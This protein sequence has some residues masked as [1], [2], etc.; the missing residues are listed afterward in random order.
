MSSGSSSSGVQKYE[1]S[2]DMKDR[3]N[4]ALNRGERLALDSRYQPYGGQRNAGPAYNERAAIANMGNFAA[5]T[6]SPVSYTDV[7]GV[8]HE[9]AYNLASDYTKD[10]LNGKYL[11]PSSP[12]ADPSTKMMNQWG[13]VNPTV[14]R[15]Q[16]AGNSPQFDAVRQQ[17]ADKLITNYKMAVEPEITRR[18]VMA[19]A[20]GGSADDKA[21]SM[22]QATLAK[23]LADTDAGL[24]NDQYRHSAGL[25]EAFLG[26]DFANQTNNKQL[27]AQLEENRIGRIG[28]AFQ[29]ER[30]RMGAAAGA[31]Y[32]E[33]GLTMDRIRG[34]ME[35]G[36]LDR[37]FNQRDLD[38]RYQEDQ[39]AK[40]WAY[41]QQDILWNLYTR[42]LGGTSP[43]VTAYGGGGSGAGNALAAIL[44]AAAFA[45][46]Y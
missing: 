39:D 7:N 11:S 32:G 18:M 28:N 10:V 30:G 29:A 1:W 44:G 40:N 5:L 45:P 19:G 27:G 33:Q 2:D 37:G 3:L 35:T 22:A 42:A 46:S 15:N 31:G 25:E 38:F 13:S 36:A 6:P 20:L 12:F 21:R 34:L 26:R 41:K 23:Q 17:A 8:H 14:Q 24:L 9:G 43:T 16:Y 4:N